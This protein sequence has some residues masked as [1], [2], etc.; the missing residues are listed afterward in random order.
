MIWSTIDGVLF[1]LDKFIFIA[2][3]LLLVAAMLLQRKV[4]S[5]V[6]TLIVLTVANGAMTSLSPMLYQYSIQPGVFTK[7]VWYA[8][9][10]AIDML[11][12]FLLFKFHQL[13]KQNV[14]FIANLVG[15]YFVTFAMLQ[16]LR[17]VDRYVLNTEL[18]QQVYQHAIPALNLVLVPI[19]LICWVSEMRLNQLYV[20]A[21]MT[22]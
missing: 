20:K 7:F 22:R 8:S 12:V 19:I 3:F 2:Y 15:L 5:F 14:G 11:A 1:A 18:L 9:F 6:I 10:A 4:S 17:F 16:T 21:G 13:L